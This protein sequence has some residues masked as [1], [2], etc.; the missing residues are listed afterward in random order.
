[1]P[2]RSQYIW[3]PSWLYNLLLAALTNVLDS[4]LMLITSH[5]P[6]CPLHSPPLLTPLARMP[7]PAFDA[8]RQPRV[9]AA[10]TASFIESSRRPMNDMLPP[11]FSE[12]VLG[13]VM[14]LIIAGP[15]TS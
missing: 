9:R 13:W 5:A 11:T 14:D 1:M 3:H 10:Y 15:S 8:I 2:L 7:S 6:C 4:L 12:Y